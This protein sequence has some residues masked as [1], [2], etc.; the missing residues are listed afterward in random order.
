MPHRCLPTSE[1][2]TVSTE[3]QWRALTSPARLEL[4]EALSAGGE[5]SVAELAFALDRAPDGLY[6]HLRR[7][8][9]AGLVARGQRRE[10]GRRAEAVFRLAHAD[11]VFDVDPAT[12]R[13]TERFMG[14][15]RALLRRAERYLSRAMA[16]GQARLGGA[17]RNTQVRSDLAWLNASELERANELLGELRALFERSR[18]NR[19]GALYEIGRAHV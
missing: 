7:L 10:P 8:V 14:V 3:A 4:V 15:A 5:S 6:P 1:T 18:G 17:D 2:G 11:L 16:T 9:G 19:R 13:N 12:G